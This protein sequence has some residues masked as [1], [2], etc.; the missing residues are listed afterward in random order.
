MVDC[1]HGRFPVPAPATAELL[2]GLPTYSA[3]IEKELV[4]PTGAALL[5]A[6]APTF[7][8]QPAMRVTHIGY[9]A[10]TRNPKDLPNVLRLS[11]GHSA[12]AVVSTPPAP[13]SNDASSRPGAAHSAAAVERPPHL[14]SAPGSHDES[15]TVTVLETALDDLSPQILATIID[16]AL[17]LGA[18]DAM[19]T[20]VL[21]KKGR[22]GT[23][24]TIL[25]DDQHRPALE[26]LLLTE[27]T[28]LG[29]RIRRDQRTCLDRSHVT[30]TTPYGEIRIKLGSL[31]GDVLN[32]AP[33]FEDCRT[34]AATHNVPVKQVF[35]AATSAYL[36]TKQ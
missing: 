17:A 30:V 13:L 4:T 27:T 15:T 16:R 14:V 5:R 31:H 2:R 22:P 26:R 8:P 36:Q 12:G 6:L 35:H 10:G 7:G 34:A 21:M 1:A 25:T 3:H 19:L 33:E 23:L 11:L 28:T 24:I 18:L 20:P 32:I 29:I 9:G